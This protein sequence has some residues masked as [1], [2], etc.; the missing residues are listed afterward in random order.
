MQHQAYFIK[1]TLV[2]FQIILHT[3][4]FFFILLSIEFLAL[5][6]IFPFIFK[7]YH[8]LFK[9]IAQQNKN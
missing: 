8:A 9:I 2:N 6:N 4:L 7:L 3:W 5:W 1:K